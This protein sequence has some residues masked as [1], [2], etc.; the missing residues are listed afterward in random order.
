[1]IPALPESFLGNLKISVLRKKLVI[2][3]VTLPETKVAPEK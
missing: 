3:T 2:L 1:M